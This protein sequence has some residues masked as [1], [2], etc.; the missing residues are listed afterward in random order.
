MEEVMKPL[1][2]DISR[3]RTVANYAREKG[4]ST[5]WVY[6]MGEAKEVDI[7]EIDGTKF[8]VV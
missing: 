6:K 4:I 2:V 7:I 1:K 3:L 5:T 8:V